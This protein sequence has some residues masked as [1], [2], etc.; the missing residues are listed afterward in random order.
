[1]TG[2]VTVTNLNTNE[3]KVSVVDFTVMATGGG[4]DCGQMPTLTFNDLLPFAGSYAVEI[5]TVLSIQHS[6]KVLL[7]LQHCN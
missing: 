1:M 3:S 4:A 7:K 5:K 2:K 6:P